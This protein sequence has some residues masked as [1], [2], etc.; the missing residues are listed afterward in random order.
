MPT[1]KLLDPDTER[2]VRAFLARV[3]A[4]I[5]DRTILFGSRARREHHRDR[6]LAQSGF[7]SEAR[8]PTERRARRHRSVT[9]APFER[10][11]VR[12]SEKALKIA[13]LALNA[14][15]DDS[16]VSRS[17]Y[18][19]LDIARAALLRAGVAEDKLPRAHSG[20]IDAFRSHAVKSGQIDQRQATQLSRTESLR[21]LADYTG[22]EIE[23]SEAKEVIRNAELFVQTVEQVFHLDKAC[24]AKQYEN[25]VSKGDDK[26][27][28]PAK[29]KPNSLE[30]IRRQARENWLRL[31]QHEVGNAKG[32]GYFTE[33][34]R[35][36]KE[37]QGRSIDDDVE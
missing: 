9:K 10:A 36:V 24:L 12:K 11:L 21:I 37:D 13:K 31:R 26:V 34:D 29:L 22:A 18:A 20:V 25:L 16:A 28:E 33:T 14:G 5:Q 8:V 30:D 15:D 6:G 32:V 1:M 17:Y 35:V 3:P 7:I 19:M 27:S 2:A 4:D 23:L